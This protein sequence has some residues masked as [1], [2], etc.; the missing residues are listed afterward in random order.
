MQCHNLNDKNIDRNISLKKQAAK[1][2]RLLFI[3]SSSDD[4]IAVALY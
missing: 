1:I 4:H 3:L 2:F